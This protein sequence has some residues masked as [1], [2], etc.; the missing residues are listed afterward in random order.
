MRPLTEDEIAYLNINIA[1]LQD[2]LQ[3]DESFLAAVLTKKCITVRHEE[4]IKC[5]KT[6]FKKNKKFLDVLRRRSFQSWTDF[7]AILRTSKHLE[8]VADTLQKGRDGLFNF[9]VVFVFIQLSYHHH[10]RFNV[11]F[12]TQAR[13]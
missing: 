12:S 6:K 9:I 4:S 11:F 3:P 1:P 10:N 13:V 5:K 7:I 8:N 2:I